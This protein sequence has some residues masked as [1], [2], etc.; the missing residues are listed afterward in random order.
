MKHYITIQQILNSTLLYTLHVNKQLFTL[1][2]RFRHV[3]SNVYLLFSYKSLLRISLH[4]RLIGNLKPGAEESCLWDL[5]YR[6]PNVELDIN[7]KRICQYCQLFYRY[8]ECY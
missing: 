8:W 5:R 1:I 4:Q 3:W 7:K 6:A 2:K